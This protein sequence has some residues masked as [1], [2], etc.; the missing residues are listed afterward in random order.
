MGTAADY[1]GGADSR[2]ARPLIFVS[3]AI[4]SAAAGAIREAAGVPPPPGIKKEP[5]AEAEAIRGAAA[6]GVQG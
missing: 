6:G 3:E 5:P 2:A 4:I 1:S